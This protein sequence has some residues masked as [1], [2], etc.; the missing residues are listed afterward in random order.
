M[1]HT[2]RTLIA[3]Q[4]ALALPLLQLY[5]AMKGFSLRH[6]PSDP[7]KL[8]LRRNGTEI[9]LRPS[10]FP[11]VLDMIDNYDYYFGAVLPSYYEQG[12]DTVDY[13]VT[14]EHVLAGSRLR[15]QFTSLAE[16]DE[17]TAIYL[18]CP[19]LTVNAT[20]WDLGAY[21]GAS[22]ILFSRTVGPNGRV[23]GFEPDIENYAALNVN[24]VRHRCTNAQVFN[25]AVW[26]HAT[27]LEFQAEGS[28]GSAAHNAGVHTRRSATCRVDALS[29][30]E[31]ASFVG[32]ATV[33]LVK[34][35]I[36][37]AELPALKAARSQFWDL[38]PQ[39]IIEPHA[40]RGKVN[41]GAILGILRDQDYATAVIPQAGL[42]L[43]LILATPTP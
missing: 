5:A 41:T 6:V 9:L 22:T 13:S 34:M 8:S 19:R 20:V 42:H 25:V 18:K 26:S 40:T 2:L 37:G 14:R 35:D 16:P 10:H 7:P 4:A 31:L 21:C 36:E 38:R 15:M 24:L 3:T 30:N 27:T 43:P 33:D 29:L 28:M 39:L 1:I 17:T 12:V 23:Y 32:C 11:Y